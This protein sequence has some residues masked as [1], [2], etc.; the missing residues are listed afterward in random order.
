MD[1]HRTPSPDKNNK[2]I[3]KIRQRNINKKIPPCKK[4]N[5]P[6]HTLDKCHFFP[7][8]HIYNQGENDESTVSLF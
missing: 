1:F 2:Q 8:I 7:S 4:I 3:T 5:Q 6:C